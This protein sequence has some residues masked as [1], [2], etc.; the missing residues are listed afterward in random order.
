MQVFNVIDHLF[1]ARHDRIAVVEGII[2][3]KHIEY[4]TGMVSVFEVTLHHR[5]FI[6]IG[7]QGQVVIGLHVFISL[8][9]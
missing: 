5:Q 4:D 8:V 7:E 3:V 1:E 2:P 6:E 9:W